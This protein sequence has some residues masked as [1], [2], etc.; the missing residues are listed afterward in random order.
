MTCSAYSNGSVKVCAIVLGLPVQQYLVIRRPFYL[1][2]KYD[3]GCQS[4]PCPV[5]FIIF[6]TYIPNNSVVMEPIRRG[7]AVLDLLRCCFDGG[8]NIA[9]SIELLI[10]V[11]RVADCY[12]LT[13][14]NA[15]EAA[16]RILEAVGSI[17]PDHE[18]GERGFR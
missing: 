5:R 8:G 4:Q 17:L 2:R 1:S 13:Y 15:H 12:R 18:L 3:R 11:A 6:P 10:S 9:E 16:E 7:N 14:G